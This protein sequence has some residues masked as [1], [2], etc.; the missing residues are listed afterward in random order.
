[1]QFGDYIA[2]V[3]KLCVVS[4]HFSP[5]YLDWLYMISHPFMSP[6]QSGNPP[7]VPPVQQDEEFVEP[8]MYQ[9]LMAAAVP[10]EADIDQHHLRHVVDDFA[11]IADK[12][13]KLLNRRIL[14]ERT[15]A[16][17]V[18]EECVG[19]ARHYIGQPTVAHR[20]RRR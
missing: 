9:Q 11:A 4:G 8:D 15:E 14:I 2:L 6:A 1:M 20:S 17:T 10:N 3:G 7:R 13:D 19:I 12:L 16:Y 5:D 18:V